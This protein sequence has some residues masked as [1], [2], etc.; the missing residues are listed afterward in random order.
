MFNMEKNTKN[1]FNKETKWV[2]DW[3]RDK[4]REFILA[5]TQWRLML[6]NEKD[7][8]NIRDSSNVRVRAWQWLP[9][10]QKEIG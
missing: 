6:E 3:R 9:E 5:F 2:R 7:S 4:E 10:Q 8:N 1:E